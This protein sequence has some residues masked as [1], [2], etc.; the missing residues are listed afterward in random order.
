[1]GLEQ[2]F[3]TQEFQGAIDRWAKANRE[4]I[5]H[6]TTA[7]AKAIAADVAGGSPEVL[8]YAKI[9]GWF[10]AL[11]RG[12]GDK[13]TILKRGRKAGVVHGAYMAEVHNRG[14]GQVVR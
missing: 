7:G 6:L 5:N 3:P 12:D 11:V 13:V 10:Y 4:M 2:Y 8:V 14:Y 9:D 1:M